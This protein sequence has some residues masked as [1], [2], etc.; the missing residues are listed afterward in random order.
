MLIFKLNNCE[1]IVRGISKRP[2]ENTAEQRK[3]DDLNC[4]AYTQMLFSITEEIFNIFYVD[5]NEI[6]EDRAS[7]FWAMLDRHFTAQKKVEKVAIRLKLMRIQLAEG[8]DLDD[9]FNE[10]LN[11]RAL[12]AFAGYKMTDEEFC[13]KI[14]FSLPESWEQTIEQLTDKSDPDQLINSLRRI[15]L[16]NKN[17]DELRRERDLASVPSSPSKRR[18]DPATGSS[19]RHTSYCEYCRR[20]NHNTVDCWFAPGNSGNRRK[21][22][23]G[24]RGNGTSETSS[25]MFGHVVGVLADREQSYDGL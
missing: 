20:N 19:S 3:W 12:G 14:L 6:G 5:I 21:S 16:Y 25:S 22:T 4:Y 15:D 9:H 7:K 18:T 1:D 8:E 17:R 23:K 10:L 24:R 11:L 13:N 2:K